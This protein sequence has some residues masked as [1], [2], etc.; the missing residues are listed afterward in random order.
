LFDKPNLYTPDLVNLLGSARSPDQTLGQREY[1]IAAAMQRITEET[2]YHALDALHE[3]TKSKNLCVAGGLFMNSLMNGKIS[4]NTPFNN[5]YVSSCPDDSGNAIGAALYTY[6]QILEHSSR[7]PLKHTFLGPSFSDDQIAED[8][9]KAG[10]V[11]EKSKN[12]TQQVAELLAEGKLVGWFQGRMEAGQRALGNR[13]IFADPRDPTAKGRINAAVKFREGFRPF[14]PSILEEHFD[15]YFESSGENTVPYM[16]KILPIRP[17]RQAEI[18]AV[19][20]QG[21]S[22]RVQTVNKDSNHLLYE[23]IQEFHNITGIPIL[24]N[25]SFNLNAEPIVCNPHDA[26]RTFFSCGLDVLVIGNFILKKT[27]AE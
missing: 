7:I 4:K 2:V 20:H 23:L 1:Q 11:P 6:H 16:E 8:I 14:A 12:I 5:I 21:G 24:L 27:S 22:G 3:R 10:L 17:E 9:A 19:V 26:L 13:S 25:T 18:P 15:T